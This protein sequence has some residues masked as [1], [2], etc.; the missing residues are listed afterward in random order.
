MKEGSPQLPA[1]LCCDTRGLPGAQRLNTIISKWLSPQNKSA[2]QPEYRTSYVRSSESSSGRSLCRIT[3]WDSCSSRATSS[4]FLLFALL[5]GLTGDS[6]ISA[7]IHRRQ[8]TTH[9]EQRHTAV[10]SPAF[11]PAQELQTSC[12][13]RLCCVLLGCKTSQEAPSLTLGHVALVPDCWPVA[14][15]VLDPGGED[16]EE[17]ACSSPSAPLGQFSRPSGRLGGV[18][19]AD[20]CS[21]GDHES[22]PC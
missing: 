19:F 10:C 7:G 22:N 18:E 8:I 17:E 6:L 9:I 16:E 12:V 14:Q 5:D 4:R 1:E 15:G 20:P 2:L 11:Y 3:S 13:L 21:C